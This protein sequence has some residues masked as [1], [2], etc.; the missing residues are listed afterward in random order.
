MGSGL[1]DSAPSASSALLAKTTS[2]P[3]NVFLAW[4]GSQL[5]PGAPPKGWCPEI[6][7]QSSGG[8]QGGRVYLH[9]SGI[10]GL[11]EDAGL[12]LNIASGCWLLHP[13]LLPRKT[14]G[15]PMSSSDSGSLAVHHGETKVEIRLLKAWW[16]ADSGPLGSL[17]RRP[18]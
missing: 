14:L 18:L 12:L 9:H 5:S 2:V 13:L 7:A 3:C 4:W 11:T 15:S 1:Y 10:V 6:V 17:W 8:C 16:Q